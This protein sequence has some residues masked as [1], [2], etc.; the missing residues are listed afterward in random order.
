MIKRY[1]RRLFFFGLFLNLILLGLAYFGLQYF[2]KSTYVSLDLP[3]TLTAK[4]NQLDFPISSTPQ[5]E[6]QTIDSQDGLRYQATNQLQYSILSDS[7]IAINPLALAQLDQQIID[8][9][10]ANYPEYLR[11][12]N[13]TQELNLYFSRHDGIDPQKLNEALSQPLATDQVLES[14]FFYTSPDQSSQAS[15]KACTF[16]NQV[17][18]ALGQT[19]PN[20]DKS[21]YDRTNYGT[22][23]GT[24]RE[25]IH[26]VLVHELIHARLNPQAFL[27]AESNES[28]VHSLDHQ[29]ANLY[30]PDVL[31]LP[32]LE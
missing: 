12:P 5:A 25:L 18:L 27:N 10:L 17:I 13:P 3:V 26:L 14:P 32:S 1:S 31:R 16:K 11:Q 9:L 30:R 22:N 29:L 4:A 23:Y 15:L 2:P 7:S 21:R 28:F 20:W 24:G 6:F 8:H 19:L